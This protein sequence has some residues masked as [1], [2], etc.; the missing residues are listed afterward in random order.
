M[1]Y[2]SQTSFFL[3]IF[4]LSTSFAAT[5][6]I[7]SDISKESYLPSAREISVLAGFTIGSS[8]TSLKGPAGTVLDSK[9]DTSKLS[10]RLGYGLTDSLT[11]GLQGKY[12]I[13]EKTENSYG[14]GS[15]LN[16]A[17][18]SLKSSGA[19]EPELNATL[20][21]YN[22]ASSNVRV[23]ITAG[24]SPKLQTSK[25]ATT[26]SD[27]NAG[28]GANQYRLMIGFYKEVESVE[29]TFALE[30]S[31]VDL[32]KTEDP[33]DSQKLTEYAES[34]KTEITVG[35]LKQ[36]TDSLSLGAAF[37]LILSEGYKV[38]GYTGNQ[39]TSSVNYDASSGTAVDLVAKY[40][41]TESTLITFDVASLLNY[42]QTAK[43]GT[44]QLNIGDASS[45][46]YRLAWMQIF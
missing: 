12:L 20:N 26:T 10:Y 28:T 30:R 39:I 17:T 29:M 42:S 5:Q 43:S 44:T 1:K 16:G 13:G 11:L 22:N 4:S 15:T 35:A 37:G 27:G 9:E 23:N 38:T 45:N 18:N 46:S 40:K 8:K 3:I 7:K 14:P 41:A 2:N 34:Q 36:M 24:I 32:K 25:Y 33:S 6:S 21:V 31:F 19:E